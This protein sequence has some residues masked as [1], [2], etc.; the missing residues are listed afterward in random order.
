MDPQ[1]QKE[2]FNYAYVCALAAHAGLNRTSSSVD[3]D[4]IDVAFKSKGY[5]GHLVRSPQ[6]E[7]QLKCTSQNLVDLDGE[8]IRF[9]LPRK[10]YDDLRGADFASPRYLAVLLVPED[11]EHWIGHN[12]EHIELH[13]NCYW[14]SLR[15]YEPTDNTNTV[16]V[17]IPLH[18]RLTTGTLKAMMDR[19]S[20]GE[21]L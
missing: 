1:K 9:P 3:D 16:T 4:S 14:L 6:I 2:E 20:D 7:F 5:H 21:W 19:A 10:N 18:Q 12:D 11:V 17:S 15:D 8:V 13:K